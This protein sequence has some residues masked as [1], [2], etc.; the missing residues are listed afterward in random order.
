MVKHNSTTTQSTH[1]LSEIES[2]DTVVCHDVDDKTINQAD[3]D[4]STEANTEA[5]LE[6]EAMEE[7]SVDVVE[8]CEL[9]EEVEEE[10]V[11]VVE[12]TEVE[13]E[14]NEQPST[15]MYMD[16]LLFYCYVINKLNLGVLLI[17][18]SRKKYLPSPV[19]EFSQRRIKVVTF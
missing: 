16:N 6:K 18:L 12:S 13:C 3:D 19:T 1:Y 14:G 4:D 9:P 8:E 11:S 2:E 10:T 17:P 5:N 15:L 7:T